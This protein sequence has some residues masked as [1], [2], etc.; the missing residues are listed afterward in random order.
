MGTGT[1]PDHRVAVAHHFHSVSTTKKRKEEDVDK[2]KDIKAEKQSKFSQKI[3]A[4]LRR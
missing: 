2:T 3:L 1:I 4:E